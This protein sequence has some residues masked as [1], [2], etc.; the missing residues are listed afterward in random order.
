[1]ESH[2]ISTPLAGCATT[3]QTHFKLDCGYYYL[4][5]E[6]TLVDVLRFLVAHPSESLAMSNR[7]GRGRETP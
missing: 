4:G 5:A 2:G 1:M 7:D 3:E 6:G